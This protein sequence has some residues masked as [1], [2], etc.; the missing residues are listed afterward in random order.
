LGITVDPQEV[1]K[2]KIQ[3]KRQLGNAL[4][5]CLAQMEVIRLHVLLAVGVPSPALTMSKRIP[6]RQKIVPGQLFGIMDAN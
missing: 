5:F 3:S 1:K 6:T 2:E 4:V